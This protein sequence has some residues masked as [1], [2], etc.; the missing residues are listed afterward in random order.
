MIF[1]TLISDRMKPKVEFL[2]QVAAVSKGE[3]IDVRLTARDHPRFAQPGR[4]ARGQTGPAD[5]GVAAAGRS[6]E[7]QARGAGNLA[8]L[9]WEGPLSPVSLPADRPERQV[10][11]ANGASA[12][13][14]YAQPSQLGL[15]L[16]SRCQWR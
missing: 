10:S 6:G 12:R 9:L 4:A 13:S 8:L 14:E 2:P 16:A 15:G 5:A 7:H 3:S 1:S 11:D